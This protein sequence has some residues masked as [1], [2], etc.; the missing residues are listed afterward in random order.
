MFFLKIK[1]QAP[2]GLSGPVTLGH[3]SNQPFGDS[4]K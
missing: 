2:Q 4:D 1:R 3:A